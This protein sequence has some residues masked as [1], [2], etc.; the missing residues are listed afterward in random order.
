MYICLYTWYIIIWAPSLSVHFQSRWHWNVVQKESEPIKYTSTATKNSVLHST[1]L[2]S[3]IQ[4][5]FPHKQLFGNKADDSILG[6][7]DWPVYVSVGVC[8]SRP[9]WL[10]P[11]AGWRMLRRA[12]SEVREWFP[13]CRYWRLSCQNNVR[14]ISEAFHSLEPNVQ[15]LHPSI[16]SKHPEIYWDKIIAFFLTNVQHIIKT[17][18]NV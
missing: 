15:G 8:I 6:D 14:I 3:R 7:I 11:I 13:Q 17:N 10:E 16:K 9:S 12:I 5:R 18:Q 4:E 2:S 1:F